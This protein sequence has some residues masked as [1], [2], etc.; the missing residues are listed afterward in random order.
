MNESSS[1]AYDWSMA[2]RTCYIV[3]G[4]AGFV[5]SNLC[6]GLAQ[7]AERDQIETDL[8]VIDDFRS[9]SH[10]NLVEAFARDDLVG[11]FAG[12]VL[13]ASVGEIDWEG[14]LDARQPEAVFHLGAI[15]DTTVDDEREM[16]EA[17][18]E[19]FGPILDACVSAGVP[20]V[21]ASSA[22]TY[23]TPAQAAA[24]VPFPIEAAGHPSNVYG[25]SKW[26]MECEHLRIQRAAADAGKSAP[27]VVGL[28]Y[29]NVF[30][31]GESRKGHMASMVHKLALQLIAGQSPKLFA[32]G[33]QARDQVPVMD[34]VGCTIAAAG[35][36]TEHAIVPG[37]YNLGS[38]RA[39][40]FN[41]MLGSLRDALGITESERP[42]EYFQMPPS[43]RAFYQDFTCA[44]MNETEAGLGWTPEIDPLMA[45]GQLA[46]YLQRSS[47]VVPAE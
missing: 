36:E 40:S 28:R 37:V 26:L 22:A 1:R 21:Y 12:E 39:T 34:V 17:N 16:L 10:A 32:D 7:R 27:H 29:F 31:P 35:I 18:T 8:V 13:V 23:G 47:G 38:G 5:G 20:L 2:G 45:M 4:G 44:D 14:L 11:P 33:D 19:T 3:T 24:R 25:F 6:L 46:T 42:T 41:E 30:G 43:V 15:T 9:G